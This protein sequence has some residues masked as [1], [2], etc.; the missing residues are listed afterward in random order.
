MGDEVWEDIA[1][2][3]RYTQA[4][5]TKIASSADPMTELLA[6][7]KRRGGQPYEFISAMYSIGQY[8]TSPHNIKSASGRGNV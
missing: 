4:E 5:I 7:Y 3:L 8:K 6:N 2:A 1:H